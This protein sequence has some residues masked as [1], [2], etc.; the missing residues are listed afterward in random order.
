MP[1]VRDLAG[2]TLSHRYRLMSPLAGGG[3]GTVY[4]AHDLLLDRSVAVKVLAAS[5]ATEPSLV[6]RFKQEARAAARLSHPHVVAVHD[7]GWEAPDTY[8]LVMELVSGSD[9][10]EVLTQ[11]GRVDWGEAAQIVAAVCDALQTAHEIG[12]VHRDIKPENVLIDRTG[13]VRVADFGIAAVIDAENATVPGEVIPGTLRYLAPEQAAGGEAAP[14]SDI[15]AA[16][17]LLYELITGRPPDQG[18]GIELLRRRAVEAIPPPSDLLEG[19]DPWIDSICVR[20]CA[21][22]PGAR[23]SSAAEM[24][25]DLRLASSASSPLAALVGDV[26]GEIL[27]ADMAPTTR[28]AAARSRRRPRAPRRVALAVAGVLVFAGGARGVAALTAP[29]EVGV[30]RVTGLPKAEALHALEEMG[31]RVAVRDRTHSWRFAEGHVA[32][33]TP[34]SGRLAE[35]SRVEIV[36]SAG[37]PPVP[38]PRLVGLDLEAAERRLLARG[39]ALG[40]VRSRHHGSP[41]GTVIRQ[42][43]DNGVLEF[44]GSVDVVVSKGPRLVLV[45]AV[46]GLARRSAVEAIRSAGLTPVVEQVYSDSVEPGAIV[47]TD[48][49][50]GTSV[51]EGSRVRVL[52]SMGPRY[53]EV[54]MPDVRGMTVAAATS[55]LESMRLRVQVRQSCGGGGTIVAD[56]DPISGTSIRENDLVVLFVC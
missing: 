51:P 25:A 4:R 33:Q 15:W 32:L 56:T 30:P 38:L 42:V 35:G 8:Y 36:L 45:P 49:G 6:A 5:L 48:P 19:V 14:T 31:F 11:R 10:R 40:Q 23:Y 54:R 47:G 34:S 7:W 55:K 43:P 12:L 53:K 16:G 3:M 37:P 24:A 50:V 27:R 41:A 9:L 18:A 22:D 13:R 46:D 44:G 29:G 17:L 1:A 2:A 39:S 21:V 28:T 20:A 52:V 26:T